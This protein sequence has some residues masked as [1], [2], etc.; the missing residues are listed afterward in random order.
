[1]SFQMMGRTIEKVGVI[2]SGQIGPDIA[3]HFTKFFA[4]HGV[5]VVVVDVAEDALAKGRAKCEKKVGKGMKV[6]AFTEE[7]GAAMLSNL[8]FT[9]DYAELAGAGLVVE[10]AT[11]S[12]EIKEKIFAQLE[13][14]CGEGAIL[15]SNSS[16]MTPETIF[17]KASDPS[18]T[19]VTHYFFP[20]ERNPLVEIVPGAKTAKDVTDFLMRF[21]EIIGKMPVQVGSRY[22]FAV[23]PVFEGLVILACKI[24]EAGMCDVKQCDAIAQKAIGL[25]VGPFTAMN[26]T[27]G[28]ALVY[29][30][31]PGYGKHVM[32]FFES[33]RSMG[34][35]LEKKA[36]WPTAGRD[37]KVEIPEEIGAE[38]GDIIKG[39]YF[40]LVTDVVD[41]GVST[42]GDLDLAVE[43][44]LVVRSPFGLMNRTG[45][46]VSLELAEKAAA[47]FPGLKIPALLREK[48]ASGK[49][50]E[51]PTVFRRDAGDVAVVQIRRPR[52][53]NA[54]NSGV[55]AQL[56]AIF[57]EIQKD[58]GI[59]G[60]VLTGFGTK[61][62]VS[63]ADINELARLKSPEEAAAFALKGQE[64]LNLIENLGKPVVA[65]MNGLALGGGSEIA[66]ACH[67]RLAARGQKM[68]AGQPEPRL[69]IIPGF[70]GTQRFVRWVG[71]EAAWP[72]LRTANPISSARAAE[73]GYVREETERQDL[74]DRAVALVRE[75]A[76]GQADLP[77]IPAAPV[78]VPGEPAEVD[79]G[80][81]S[82]KIDGILQK[83]V[84]E[85]AK[86]DLSQGLRHEAKMFGECLNTED[87][88][89]GMENFQK[90]GPKVDAQ[91]KN[92]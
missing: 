79:I 91:F 59:V 8:R 64:T 31:A 27:G 33:P 11:E 44:G 86:M 82:T 13:S 83:A 53:L 26:L 4:P 20:A 89:I 52:V 14:I 66:L 75:A 41:A 70:G 71:F 15:T 42:V 74:L 16:H 51:V 67:A 25:G 18:R 32:P 85:G 72:I 30:G 37:E 19:L 1:M 21:Y 36:F 50:W 60:A 81:L 55:V 6:G 58:A 90:N 35:M 5:P 68:F 56:D 39:A 43:T 48:A 65:A 87:M 80:H 17:Q 92:A 77:S 34:E 23:D 63:G 12:L 76:A 29:P 54:L 47:K 40:I 49:P 69:G 57:R 28:N 78:E 9:S 61:S 46:A 73:I 38:V 88:K 3:L 24:V 7:G 45:V 84:V 62:F 2:G 22:G 10:A